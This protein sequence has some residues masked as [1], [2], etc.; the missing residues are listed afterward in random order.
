[1]L[2]DIPHSLQTGIFL[3]FVFTFAHKQN[4][5]YVWK[6]HIIKLL[7]GECHRDGQSL[8]LHLFYVRRMSSSGDDPFASV[9]LQWPLCITSIVDATALTFTDT[10]AITV[11]IALLYKPHTYFL[12]HDQTDIVWQREPP[13]LLGKLS[14]PICHF[15]LWSSYAPFLPHFFSIFA[16]LSTSTNWHLRW[17]R[18]GD[19]R[20]IRSP[21]CL[22][23]RQVPS[24]HITFIFVLYCFS[25]LCAYKWRQV[26]AEKHFQLL[27]FLLKK[28][29]L[30][31][32][33]STFSK[34][35]V[36]MSMHTTLTTNI[37]NVYF[38]AVALEAKK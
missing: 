27:L 1:M 37:A 36:L 9:S 28:A 18:R 29:K 35:V 21:S 15:C 11:D 25:H 30:F 23:E 24:Q 33:H 22:K 12:T 38:C 13:L 34:D 6:L 4:F 17:P 16:A 5:Q 10:S 14:S 19:E 2:I 26:P 8:C 7:S 20:P 31:E 32:W 3:D